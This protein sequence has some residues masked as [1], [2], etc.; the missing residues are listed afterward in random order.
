MHFAA[1]RNFYLLQISIH[2]IAQSPPAWIRFAPTP[3][4]GYARC[5]LEFELTSCDDQWIIPVE[6]GCV[7]LLTF[8][9]CFYPARVWLR[10]R[11][12]LLRRLGL[13]SLGLS[14][15]ARLR[16]RKWRSELPGRWPP[17]N[18]RQFL[19]RRTGPRWKG[20]R[21]GSSRSVG[22]RLPSESDNRGGSHRA[23][24]KIPPSTP[25]PALGRSRPRS[26]PRP[27]LD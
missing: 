17:W 4:L 19:W 14:E 15:Y 12:G 21:S 3:L 24:E 11:L 13:G 25:S 22:C 8:N 7:G 27:E 6:M 5:A 20:P 1:I 23:R 26:G 16:R 18:A 9:S 10:R 2:P